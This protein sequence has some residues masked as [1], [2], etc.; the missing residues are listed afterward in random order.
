MDVPTVTTQCPVAREHA[1]S[2]RSPS[3]ALLAATVVS[4]CL[5]LAAATYQQSGL[6][7]AGRANGGLDL[8]GVVETVSHHVAASRR[9]PGRLVTRDHLYSAEFGPD[10]VTVSLRGSRFGLATSS[11]SFGGNAAALSV[12]SWRSSL[13]TASRPL[14][15][16]LTERITALDRKLEWEFVLARPPN[17]SGPLSIEADVRVERAPKRSGRRP[18]WPQ[19]RRPWG[20]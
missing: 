13:N 11:V 1:S 14:T 19:T 5:T 2:H 9:D 4:L 3:E 8:A 20:R 12:E 18:L 16:G 7:A 17:I 15:A 6:G 10:G